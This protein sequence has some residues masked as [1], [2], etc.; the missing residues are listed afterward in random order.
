MHGDNLVST[1]KPAQAHENGNQQSQRQ[2]GGQETRYEQPIIADD[3]SRAGPEAEKVRQI[4]IEVF[5]QEQAK[6]HS[7]GKDK[8]FQPFAEDVAV[9]KIHKI[10]SSYGH[11]AGCGME[12]DAVISAEVKTWRGNFLLANRLG[13]A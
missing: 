8:S 5:E 7:Q 2:N 1:M 11:G 12:Q 6:G 9:D 10:L 4:V 13:A 3:L